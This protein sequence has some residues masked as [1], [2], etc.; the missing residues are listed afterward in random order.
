MLFWKLTT[1]RS[2]PPSA[3]PLPTVGGICVVCMK[4]FLLAWAGM[5]GVTMKGVDIGIKIDA[6][7]EYL[8]ANGCNIKCGRPIEEGR[9]RKR[10]KGGMPDVR[11]PGEYIYGLNISQR[12]AY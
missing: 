2:S 9:V 4:G 3:E 12:E 11:E 1:R 10:K 7:R 6:V 8:R 5:L